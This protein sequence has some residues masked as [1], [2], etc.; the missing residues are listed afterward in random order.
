MVCFFEEYRVKDFFAKIH[1]NCFK[2]LIFL[3]EGTFTWAKNIKF[4]EKLFRTFNAKYNSINHLL[5]LQACNLFL[6]CKLMMQLVK[7]P[8]ELMLV[9]IGR[10]N[11][12][13]ICQKV[14]FIRN[15]NPVISFRVKS[16]ILLVLFKISIIVKFFFNMRKI[17][18]VL[19]ASSVVNYTLLIS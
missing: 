3:S 9:R 7:D 2:D 17:Y 4:A 11:T 16:C 8:Q 19:V 1:L 18:K 13:I 15:Q 14:S 6:F 12:H 5:Q 10:Y